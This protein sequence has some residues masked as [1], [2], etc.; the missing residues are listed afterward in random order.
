M[1]RK[2]IFGYVLE[3]L[4]FCVY[5]CSEVSEESDLSFHSWNYRTDTGQIEKICLILLVVYLVRPFYFLHRLLQKQRFCF[6]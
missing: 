4:L 2:L 5:V 3:E 1:G 6:N